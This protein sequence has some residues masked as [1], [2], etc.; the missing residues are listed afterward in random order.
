MTLKAVIAFSFGGWGGLKF[1]CS[2]DAHDKEISLTHNRQD[3]LGG[4]KPYPFCCPAR[5]SKVKEKMSPNHNRTA[6]IGRLRQDLLANRANAV[7]SLHLYG[8]FF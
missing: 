1:N 3:L 8:Y 2:V 4:V 7:N 5:H 6:T